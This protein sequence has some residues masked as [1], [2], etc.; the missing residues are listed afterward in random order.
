MKKNEREERWGGA[1][2]VADGGRVCPTCTRWATGVSAPVGSL[3]C[4]APPPPAQTPWC[5]SRPAGTQ[6]RAAPAPPAW[7]PPPGG[8]TA[9]QDWVM[10]AQGAPEAWGPQNNTTSPGRFERLRLR[11]P[12]TGLYVLHSD[13]QSVLARQW[14]ALCLFVHL[15]AWSWTHAF[16][17]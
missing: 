5:W 11:W 10:A 8:H 6:P 12:G 17:K 13:H 4:Q 16:D 9:Q 2:D 7:Q 15:V 3:V 14:A 1:G